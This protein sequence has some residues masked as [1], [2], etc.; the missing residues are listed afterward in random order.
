[1]FMRIGLFLNLLDEQYQISVYK[2]I[3]KKAKELG[4]EI[5][6]FQQDNKNLSSDDLVSFFPKKE[7]FDAD[8]M[9]LLISVL[10]DNFNFSKKEDVQKYWGN[11]PVISVGQKIENIPSLLIETDDS[12]K[13]LVEHLIIKH[14]YRKFLFIGG[15]RNHNDAIKREKIFKKAMEAYKPWFSD[16]D[17]TIKRGDFLEDMAIRAMEEYLKENDD[18]LPDAVV[19]AND[20]MAVGVYKFLKINNEKFNVKECAVTGFDDIP[21]AKF[22]IPSLTTIHQPLEE[23]G[24]KSLEL[25]KRLVNNEKVEKENFIESKVVYRNSCG[26]VSEFMIQPFEMKNRDGKN[27][28]K[29]AENFVKNIQSKYIRSETLLRMANRIAQQMNDI[30][31]VEGLNNVIS[32]NIMQLDLKSFCVLQFEDYD[33]K[34]S[35][36]ENKLFA[37]PLYVFRN[38]ARIFEFENEKS[39]S[40]GDFY[41]K[42]IEIGEEKPVSLIFKYLRF[43]DDVIGC[44]L[45]EASHN[46]LPYI[47]SI[48]NTI[49]QVLNR[50]KGL[51]ERKKYS[52]HLEK[53]VTLRT[54]EL[55]KA[56][57]KRMQVEAEVL[58]ISE[59]E[60]QRFSNDLHDDICQRLAGISMLCRSYSNQNGAV[61]KEQM[62]ELAQ[63]IGETLQCTRQYAHNSYPVELESLGMNYSLSNLCNSFTAQSGIKCSYVWQ[64]DENVDLDKITR[65]NL[66]RIIQEALHNVMK[67]AKATKVD[68]S[69]KSDGK[70]IVAKI[71]DN[72]C[73]IKEKIVKEKKGIGLNSME[74]RANQI[75]AKFEIKQNEP[76]GI[77]IVVKATL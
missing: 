35:L 2:G 36:R 19:C 54:E 34:K 3:V 71:S 12:M 28:L 39:V 62:V 25:M 66:F 56:N 42:F 8:G 77:K 24:E 1:M 45:Y 29:D 47:T 68:V 76:C 55:M 27:R 33:L 16:L 69:I 57:D 38:N 52:E 13:E 67:H 26:C 65:L 11:I 22:E 14:N 15:S 32:E 58:E 50:I 5:I 41:K 63:L 37:R 23:I 72:G 20:N 70:K 59:L 17:F 61:A 4:I 46:L 51:E 44:V 7:F 10:T 64:V 60:R 43:G 9:L 48:S 40:F 73:G 74:Y 21:Q 53:E 49:A 75:G 6:C 30:S 31:N 18:A